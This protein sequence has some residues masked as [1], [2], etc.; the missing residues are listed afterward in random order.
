MCDN[1][2]CLADLHIISQ[3]EYRSSL[4]IIHSERINMRIIIPKINF[5][6][7]VKMMVIE[8]LYFVVKADLTRQYTIELV[9]DKIIGK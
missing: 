9:F 4:L 1:R 7:L 2:T 5:S 6:N 8:L 3:F